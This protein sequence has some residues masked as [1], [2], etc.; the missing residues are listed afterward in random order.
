MKRLFL[1][2]I[3]LMIFLTSCTYDTEAT[4][5][6]KLNNHLDK[7]T[8]YKT[9]LNMKTIM[10]GKESTYRMK[11]TYTL[12]NKYKLEILEPKESQDI[13]IEYDGDKIYIK[14]ASI[15]QSISIS[16]VKDFNQGLLIGKFFR[17]PSKIKSVQVE[18]IDGDKYYA[19]INEVKDRN[20]YNNEQIIWLRKKDFKPYALNIV[21]EK[22]NSRVIIEYIDFEFTKD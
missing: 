21:D 22:G 13:T 4:I 14:N 10:D 7:Y 12:G 1:P 17:E 18:E 19:F 2:I 8:G 9:E 15:K 16:S 6:K 11:E 5:I 3:A 20:K